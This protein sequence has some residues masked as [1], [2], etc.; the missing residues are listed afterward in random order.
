MMKYTTYVYMF[1]PIL[2]NLLFTL[3]WFAVLVII[4]TFIIITAVVGD[5]YFSAAF[6]E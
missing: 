4:I 5:I 6:S 1:Q 2:I 3:I